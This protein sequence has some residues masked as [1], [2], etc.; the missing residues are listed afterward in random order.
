MEQLIKL[1][2]EGASV[3]AVILVVILFLKQQREQGKEIS[4][5][6]D[7]FNKRI[8]QVTTDN[9]KQN[10]ALIDRIYQHEI[11]TQ[12]QVQKL[13]D[14]FIS[15]SQETIR[16]VIELKGAV[17]KLSSKVDTLPMARRNDK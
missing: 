10:E 16:A 17:E 4:A 6:A 15:V 11:A 7:N 5:M 3:I 8:E 12:G 9:R 13:F 2:P 14:Q 1:L